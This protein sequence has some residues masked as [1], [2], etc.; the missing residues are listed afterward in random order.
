MLNFIAS[1]NWNELK[2]F[3]VK[4]L[5]Y[6][7]AK[8]EMSFSIKLG[9]ISL[10]PKGNKNRDDL[11]NWRPIS[12]LNVIYKI[13][14]GCIA[15]RLKKVLSYLIHENQKGFLKGRYIGENIRLL[16]DVMLYTELM[17][18]PGML[19]SIDFEKVFDS[20]SHDFLFK[21]LNF[22]N[23]G[24]SFIKLV[25]LF[26]DSAFSSVLVNGHMTKRFKV[27]RGCRQGDPLSPYLFLLCSEIL[28][29]LIRQSSLISGISIN[30]RIFKIVQY[31]DDTILTLN[32]SLSDLTNSLDIIKEFGMFSKRLK[33]C[34]L[35]KRRSVKKN[36]YQIVD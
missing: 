28:G 35:V 9:I 15:N 33:L 5:N 27:G 19:L 34:G 13:A 20:V 8:G 2:F 3:M 4:S 23:F 6:A 29:I 10:I 22:F 14:T 32:G 25:H 11:K 26:Y 30:G 1:V 7:Y 36:F 24:Q 31:A 18:I 21:V 16:Y 12:L 17:D